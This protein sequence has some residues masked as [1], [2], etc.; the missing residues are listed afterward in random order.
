MSF[1]RITDEL[2]NIPLH[3]EKAPAD[4]KRYVQALKK[5]QKEVFN[6][7]VEFYKKILELQIEHQNKVNKILD[8]R[9][10][11]INGEKDIK[12]EDCIEEAIS[13]LSI[14]DQEKIFQGSAT[15][16]KG[17]KGFW[18]HVLQ[19][20]AETSERIFERDEP[21]L[22]QLK[23]IKLN[24]FNN[25]E[26]DQGFILTFV[27]GENEF[28]E[29][30]ELVK[31]YKTSYHP[32]EGEEF[33]LYDGNHIVSVE[34]SKVTWKA[35]KNPLVGRQGKDSS[36]EEAQSFFEYFMVAININE[37][38]DEEDKETAF[39]DFELGQLFRDEVI[40]R[41]T[42]IYTGEYVGD[43]NLDMYEDGEEEESDEDEEN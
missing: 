19:G 32:E 26:N 13:N 4:Q 9:A 34:S 15:N 21:I 42:L 29:E 16:E 7:E 17:I 43:D 10:A 35:G 25:G 11:I 24:L 36:L 41:A 27:F 40:P 31:T 12:D 8:V 18:L 3:I 2:S 14:E 37:C 28:F 33:W 38:A 20:F 22:E 39:V 5:N 1:P 23:D 6:A 30:K